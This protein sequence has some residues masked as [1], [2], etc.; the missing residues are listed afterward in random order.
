MPLGV[1][2]ARYKRRLNKA[3]IK[4]LNLREAEI[5]RFNKAEFNTVVS[6]KNGYNVKMYVAS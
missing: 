1:A 6:S 2:S 4:E 3:A 5:D